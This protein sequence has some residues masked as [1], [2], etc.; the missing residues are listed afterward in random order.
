MKSINNSD[1]FEDRRKYPRLTICVPVKVYFDPG[2]YAE[3]WLQDMSPDGL[4]IRCDKELA[5]KINATGEGTLGKKKP[6]LIVEFVLPHQNSDSK[7]IAQCSICYSTALPPES[8]HEIAFGCLFKQFKGDCL[9]HIKDF[10]LN[11]LEPA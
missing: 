3:A 8:N 1:D 6:S 5:N 4:Q 7:I 9:T 2:K 10:F 11:E